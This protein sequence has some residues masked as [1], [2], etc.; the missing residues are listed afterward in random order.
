MLTH[1]NQPQAGR[2]TSFRAQQERRQAAPR[3]ATQHGIPPRPK[4][5][6]IQDY[7]LYGPGVWT[8]WH[9][10]DSGSHAQAKALDRESAVP[11]AI[12][13]VAKSNGRVL[14]VIGPV[15]SREG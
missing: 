7:P 6:E 11:G 5:G 15:A 13:L 9:R 8:D 1:S 12:C 14:R 10:L 3:A 2:Q 4:A